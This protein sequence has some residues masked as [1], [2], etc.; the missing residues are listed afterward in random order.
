MQKLKDNQRV[1][2]H[3]AIC[4]IRQTFVPSLPADVN[5][6]EEHFTNHNETDIRHL[7]LRTFFMLSIILKE[8]DKGIVK[9]PIVIH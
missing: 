1:N 8:N 5:K 9:R 3:L 4:W 2:S 7:L 6:I